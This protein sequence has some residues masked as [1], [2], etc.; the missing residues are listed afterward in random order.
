[1]EN[2]LCNMA[3]SSKYSSYNCLTSWDSYDKIPRYTLSLHTFINIIFAYCT[4]YLWKIMNEREKKRES[5]TQ[6]EFQ[7]E[8]ERCVM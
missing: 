7:M 5:E 8:N 6:K 2:L 3:S 1:M 4:A